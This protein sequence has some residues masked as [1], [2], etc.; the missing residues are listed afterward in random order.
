MHYICIINS[1]Y[2]FSMKYELSS[3]SSTVAQVCL[4]HATEHYC[5][6]F[7]KQHKLCTHM[8]YWAGMNKNKPA[9]CSEF[10]SGE[11]GGGRVNWYSDCP[12]GEA[13]GF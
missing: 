13:S 10:F 7:T 6:D 4:F 1:P 3:L 12:F 5:F 9:F 2:N 11:G 8:L